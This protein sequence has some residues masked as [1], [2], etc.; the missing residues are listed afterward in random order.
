MG[1]WRQMAEELASRERSLSEWERDK[2]QHELRIHQFELQFQNEELRSTQL[3]LERARDRYR[4]LFDHA[5][6]GYLAIDEH[7]RIME[8]NLAFAAL[9]GIE[10]AYVVGQRLPRFMDPA[11][12]D[13]FHMH[14]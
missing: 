1:E 14:R 6:V 8:A 10:R 3:L 13:R 2:V 11:D 5:P 4:E 9:L 7:A 12:A